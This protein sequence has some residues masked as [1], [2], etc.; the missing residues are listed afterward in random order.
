M[1]SS[2]NC[3]VKIIMLVTPEVPSR[4]F[5]VAGVVEQMFVPLIAYKVYYWSIVC[6]CFSILFRRID[7]PPLPSLVSFSFIYYFYFE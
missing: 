1:A 3:S 4:R 7:S 2:L 6:V 5:I